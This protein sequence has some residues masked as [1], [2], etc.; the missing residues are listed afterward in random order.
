MNNCLYFLVII[1]L[2]I[3]IFVQPCVTFQ[4]NRCFHNH[5]TNSSSLLFE[6]DF[7][8][9]IQSVYQNDV[10]NVMVLMFVQKYFNEQD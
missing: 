8:T 9:S 2:L 10:Q 1:L 7:Y 5:I 4:I 6:N 3:V